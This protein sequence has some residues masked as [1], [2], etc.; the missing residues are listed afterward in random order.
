MRTSSNLFSHA[1][2][3]AAFRPPLHS[4]RG[5]SRRRRVAILSHECWQRLF[6]GDPHIVGRTI[7]VGGTPFTVVGVLRPDFLLNREIMPTVGAIA[8]MD[9][10]TPPAPRCHPPTNAATKTIT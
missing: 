1:R 9:I 8:K 6:S 3:Q 2:R 10:F 4:F 5:C 7:L